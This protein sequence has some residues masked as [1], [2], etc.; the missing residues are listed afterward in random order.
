MEKN[1]LTSCSNL[2]SKDT[3]RCKYN[4]HTII[5]TTTPLANDRKD[6]YLYNC[7]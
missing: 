1:P 3:N 4:Y 2:G 5:V 7:S 6:S